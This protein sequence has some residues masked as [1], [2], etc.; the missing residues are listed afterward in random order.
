MKSVSQMLEQA[1]GPY[2]LRRNKLIC[3]TVDRSKLQT[4][5]DGLRPVQTQHALI[6][7][8]GEGDG[9]YLVPD[10][11]VGIEACF[12]PGVSDVASFEQDLANRNIKSFLADHSVDAPPIRN[13]LIDFEKK[14]LGPKEDEVFMTLESWVRRKVPAAGDMLLQMDIEGAEYGVIFDTS[15]ETLK[16]FRILVIE[17]HELDALI[18]NGR[19]ELFN[20]TFTKLLK[21]FEVV[22][23]HPNNY[24]PPLQY[25]EFSIPPLLEIT[26]LRK[27]RITSRQPCVTFPH[28]LDH[29]NV[30]NQAD[31]VLPHCWY[32][33]QAR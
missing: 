13:D 4:F 23:I 10:D 15:S 30:P 22:H 1:L 9:G 32:E 7:M 18:V 11:L 31:V 27:D 19:F 25:K 20:L 26:F 14:Y 24:Y 3:R 6:R 12:S 2:L 8:G 28:P 21:D 5:F 29:P 16:R 33:S 17:F